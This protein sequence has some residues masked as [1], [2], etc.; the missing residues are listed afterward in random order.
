MSIIDAVIFDLDGTLV[1][2]EPNYMLA[3]REILTPY[4]VPVDE[5][6]Q[7]KYVGISSRQTMMEL[8]QL[9]KIEESI[10]SLLQRK[11]VCYLEK[12][13]A[14]T[15]VFPAMRRFVELLRA[16]QVPMAVASGS[17]QVVIEEI[18][19]ITQLR[20]YFDVV[21]SSDQVARSKPA[22][23]VFLAAADKLGAA[24]ERCLVM[25]DSRY[26]VEAAKAA[27]MRC[28]AVPY[29][30]RP[31]L[32]PSFQAADFLY[33]KGPAHFSGEQVLA[34]MQKDA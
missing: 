10:E 19:A 29:D 30:L 5:Q 22:P 34:W 6:F 18:L 11:N 17:T 27:Q 12:A 13:A 21:L 20:S 31:P 1:D 14:N 28:V 33:E 15:V 9:Y 25:E 16:N 4:G 23:D 26:G 32:H 8:K 2:S 7:N 3:N 24:P